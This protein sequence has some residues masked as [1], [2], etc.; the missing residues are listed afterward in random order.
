LSTEGKKT[1]RTEMKN[2]K[3]DKK[4][5]YEVI[6][7]KSSKYI[8]RNCFLSGWDRDGYSSV[9]NYDNKFLFFLL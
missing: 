3:A 6:R 9:F 5:E 8:W 2:Q 1:A 4:N 7:M